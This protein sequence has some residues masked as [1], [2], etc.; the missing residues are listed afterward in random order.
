[1]LQEAAIPI[2]G[3][4]AILDGGMMTTNVSRKT[5]RTMKKYFII[6]SAAVVSFALV[7]CQKE[8]DNHEESTIENGVEELGVIPFDLNANIAET[9]TTLNTSTYAVTWQDSDVLYAVTTDAEWGAGDKDTD[10]SGDNIATFTYDGGIFTTD[11]VISEGSHT[12][13]FIYEGSGQKK[14][15]RAAGSTH[16]LYATQSVD[17]ANPAQNLKA[18]D[19]LVGQITKTI[20]ATLA[21]ITLSHIYTLMKVTIKNKL[22]AD[23]TA[24]KFEIQIDGEDIAGVFNVAFNTPGISLKSGGTDKITVNITNGSISNNGSIDIYFVMAPVTDFTGDVT[25]TVT[26]SES[27]TYSKTNSVS[28]LTFAA[29]TYNTANFSLKPAPM[30]TYTRIN[31]IGDLT[32]GD[33]VIVGEKSTTSY[34]IFPCIDPDNKGRIAYTE[35]YTS[36]ATVPEN[37]TTDDAS[38]VFTLTVSGSSPKTVTIYNA[39]INKYLTASSTL[40]WASSSPTSFTATST[41]NQF[42]FATAS[43][44]LGVN[45]DYNHWRDYASS[46]LVQTNDLILYKLDNRT[47]SSI[48]LSGTYPTE[49]HTGDSF[50][51][52]GLIVT[53]T[54]DDSSESVVTPTSVSTPDLSTT[55]TKKVTVSYTFKDVTKT[56]DYDVTVSALPTYTVTLADTSTDLVEASPGAGVVLPS[57]DAIGTYSFAGWSETN[58]S[59]ET[60]SAPTIIPAGDYNPTS[61]VTLYPVY[62]KTSSS[63]GWTKVAIN[64]VDAGVYIIYN[65]SGYPFDGTISSGHGNCI[66]TAITFS[67]DTATSIP[68]GALE[69]TFTAVT[70][71]FTLYSEGKGYLYASK[72][73]SGGLAWHATEESYWKY[74]NENWVYNSNS[75]RLRS[76]DASSKGLRTYGNNSGNGA[77]LLIK[78]G[79]IYT[80]YYNSSPSA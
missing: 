45:K 71:G 19:A 20:P 1:M 28:D 65:Q 74:D 13:N 34:G 78:K 62:S 47:L 16:Q 77:L 12:F 40:A 22:G 25:F 54:F 31:S 73:A 80:T 4:L 21:D 11:K 63:T 36:T 2:P 68:A 69:I 55:G 7:S 43:T 14:Y 61:N 9:K 10:A 8:V 26:D 30:L 33:Y 39:A 72:A 51:Y 41:D 24:T 42:C 50:S 75:A 44:Y 53:A 29:G 35:A 17:A 58:V 66:G 67:G 38:K 23:V 70:G 48:S 49:F 27:K 32:T 3:H 56:A 60:T 37:I 76:Y 46:T 59:V 64:A 52:A 6:L 15:H 79:T 18:N 57:R 5:M